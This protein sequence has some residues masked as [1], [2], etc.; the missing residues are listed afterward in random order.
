MD[1]EKSSSK[2]IGIKSNKINIKVIGIIVALT[3]VDLIYGLY[4]FDGEYFDIKDGFFMAGG[5]FLTNA[6]TYNNMS[7]SQDFANG[8]G[9][10]GSF[11][12]SHKLIAGFGRVNV[13]IDG[14]FTSCKP[15]KPPKTTACNPSDN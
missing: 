2:T 3:I 6:F 4:F 1:E 14:T 9:N 10:V 7:A 13:N 5:Q 8:L 15:L 11:A 12:N